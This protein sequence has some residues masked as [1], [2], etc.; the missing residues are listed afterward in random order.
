MS[1]FH[2][3]FM[4]W[5]N[6]YARL[7]YF[8]GPTMSW[9]G[10]RALLHGIHKSPLLPVGPGGIL[11]LAILESAQ[12]Q[13]LRT[14]R[15]SAASLSPLHSHPDKWILVSQEKI[16]RAL[17]LRDSMLSFTKTLS[18]FELSN[19]WEAGQRLCNPYRILWPLVPECFTYTFQWAP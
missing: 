15:S 8:T 16:W 10:G 14:P 1:K 13:Y 12:S 3:T 4:G 7:L 5:G 18:L 2:Y 9:A 6:Q 19:V 11:E 17:F